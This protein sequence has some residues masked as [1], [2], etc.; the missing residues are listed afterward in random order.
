MGK[1]IDLTGQKFGRLTVLRFH[2][3]NRHN[4]ATWLCRCSCGVEKV[5]QS[6]SLRNGSSK[7]CGCL[8]I[9]RGRAL[10]KAN[11]THGKTHTGTYGTWRAMKRRCF[12]QTHKDFA[13]WGAKGI[14]VCD[15]WLDFENFLADMGER[16][17]KHEIDRIDPLRGYEP[18][19]CRWV[20]A[21]ENVAN[22]RNTRWLTISG[23]RRTLKEWCAISGVAYP[24]ALMRLKRGWSEREAVFGKH[25][26]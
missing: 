20:I 12:E 11:R 10:G 23:V 26:T 4:Q 18:S 17:P 25:S 9:D 13:Y 22:R 6:Q 16:P 24:T 5:I 1:R 14:T 3:Q 2:G 7:S 21:R 19:N 15:R 8:R